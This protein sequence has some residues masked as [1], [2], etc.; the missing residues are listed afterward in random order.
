MVATRLLKLLLDHLRLIFEVA[1]MDLMDHRHQLAKQI[2][3]ETAA[4]V[5]PKD[6]SFTDSSPTTARMSIVVVESA[7]IRRFFVN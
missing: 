5:V 4:I 2:K 6:N 7:T 1:S 3:L